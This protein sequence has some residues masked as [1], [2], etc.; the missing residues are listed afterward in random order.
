M[1]GLFYSLGD[2][3]FLPRRLFQVSHTL[4]ATTGF[5]FCPNQ[6]LDFQRQANLMKKYFLQQPIGRR[7]MWD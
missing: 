7:I 4:E 2:M 1:K 5:A 6:K 3:L